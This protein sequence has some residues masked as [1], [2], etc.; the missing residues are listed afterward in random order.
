M[1]EKDKP[2]QTPRVREKRGGQEQNPNAP[3]PIK[4]SNPPKP[5]PSDKKS[6]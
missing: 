2:T 6:R 5:P 3:K 4:V 1:A